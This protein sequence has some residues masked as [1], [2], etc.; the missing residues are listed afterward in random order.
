M[1]DLLEDQKIH[2]IVKDYRRMFNNYWALKTII[3]EQEK[4]L[5]EKDKEILLLR[6]RINELKQ[7]HSKEE[8]PKGK[9][10]GILNEIESITNSMNAKLQQGVSQSTRI[11]NDVEELRQLI[12]V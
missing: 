11:S 7:E 2:Y 12:N 4:A 9:L 3:E 5:N 1:S 6:S 8:L 10:K